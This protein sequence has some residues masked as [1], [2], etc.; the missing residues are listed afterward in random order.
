MTAGRHSSPGSQS[1]EGRRIG[2][3]EVVAEIGR[4]G[5]GVV[6]AARHAMLGTRAAIKVMLRTGGAPNDPVFVERFLRE[7]RTAAALQ[8]PHILG[9]THFGWAGPNPYIVMPLLEGESLRARVARDGLLTSEAAARLIA[10]IAAALAFAHARG[11]LHRDLKPENVMVR[12]DGT[13]ILMDFGIA[14]D[15]EGTEQLTRTGQL[16]GTLGYMSPE[17]VNADPSQIGPPAD[18]YGLGA[19]LYDVLSG[20]PPFTGSALEI[21]S[22]IFRKRPP[23][24]AS[25]RSDVDP[26]LAALVHRCL[27]KEADDRPTAA[28]LAAA[29]AAWRPASDG[30]SGAGV[31]D[32]PSKP[33]GPARARGGRRGIVIGA[34]AVA[35][36][37]LVALGLAATGI[38]PASDD[39]RPDVEPG[40]ATD[41]P[42][43]EPPGWMRALAPDDRPP[44][45]LPEALAVR[46]A[47][48][49]VAA[50]PSIVL[51]WVPPAE[52][53]YQEDCDAKILLRT[54][55][56]FIGRDEVT[57][58]QYR[59]YAATTGRRLPPGAEDAR[60]D[61][62]VVHVTWDEA[63]T[64]AHHLGLTLPTDVEWELAAQ[65]LPS[66]DGTQPV[67]P[68]G[69]EPPRSPLACF[70]RG[71]PPEGGPWPVGRST[72]TSA[73]GCR[74]MSGNV[75]E[76]VLDFWD[77]PHGLAEGALD[78]IAPGPSP[79]QPDRIA[80]RGGSFST[81]THARLSTMLR[82]LVDVHRDENDLGIR[83]AWSRA[84]LAR[85]DAIASWVQDELAPGVAR[86]KQSWRRVVPQGE[87]M[88]P[89]ELHGLA[90]DPVG[91]RVL[92]L[93]G[94]DLVDGDF[95]K[96]RHLL[97]DLW[98]W[99]GERYTPL[100][101][102]G[103]APAP[104]FGHGMA[105]DEKRGRLVVFG[106]GV[107]AATRASSGEVWEWDGARWEL[108]HESA[109]RWEKPPS[110]GGKIEPPEHDPGPRIFP[111]MTYDP[112]S[113]RVLL[114]GG[115]RAD[116]VHPPLGG[117]WAWDG[118]AGA[119]ERLDEGVSPAP[120]DRYFATL[121]AAG[122]RVLLFGGYKRS[123]LWEWKDG[124]WSEIT[125]EDEIRN[126][127]WHPLV[128]PTPDGGLLHFTG[129]NR[130]NDTW[131]LVD[132]RWVEL[133][134]RVRPPRL[135]FTEM[136]GDPGR[137]VA[138]IVA[139][140]D[141]PKRRFTSDVWEYDLDPSD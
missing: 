109:A 83:V 92:I 94:R 44:W 24:L 98:A 19:L 134:P 52:A 74:D 137:G 139:G 15:L 132:G 39:D 71:E 112:S 96:P 124:A 130:V 111:A 23:A 35:A 13:P 135:N 42:A 138:V 40:A 67:Y 108:R 84:G 32:D 115:L 72:G 66:E 89:R 119:W 117:L 55:G 88:P 113:E 133:F 65:G 49:V 118:E 53:E 123:D 64:F 26:G 70:G 73:V 21:A 125:V 85:R 69:D 41:R 116:E 3:Y 136:I 14:K 54:S 75:W 77:M 37:A 87:P 25:L 81:K 131:R 128:V 110:E 18:V 6:Y 38:L 48:V 68:W 97:G 59:R 56:F 45:P 12:A 33:A 103:P 122:G 126:P 93:G 121:V 51:C 11:V 105:F 60:G 102:D 79:E 30:K 4:G 61:E 127:E 5:M 17:Q 31:G 76:H 34:I 63:F 101:A 58:D 57:W 46:G 43:D 28:E 95:K 20:R 99:D 80:I 47:D 107:E 22:E 1:S 104:R 120:E 100:P 129:M 90:Y 62:P 86:R 140:F 36:V 141:Y 114:F 29:L 7:A 2:E 50:D 27:A 10:P 82:L 91:A 106:G 16:V 9:V 8:H 78:P